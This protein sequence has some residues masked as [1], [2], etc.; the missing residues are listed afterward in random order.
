MTSGRAPCS[1][2]LPHGRSQGALIGTW[3]ARC[4]P[5]VRALPRGMSPYVTIE[6]TRALFAMP[7]QRGTLHM[8]VLVALSMLGFNHIVLTFLIMQ[9][10]VFKKVQF[11]MLDYDLFSSI[12]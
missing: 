6:E 2:A 11:D 7:P 3:S 8:I 10:V 1:S 12:P 4:S 9:N 5:T